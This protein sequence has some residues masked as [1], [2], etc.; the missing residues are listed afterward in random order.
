MNA[1]LL[2]ARIILATVFTVAGIGKLLDLKGS[3][4][5]LIGFG[6]PEWLAGPIG[7]SLPFLELVVSA[8]LLP[9]ATAWWGAAGAFVLLCGF[10]VAISVNVARGKRP[11]CHC[12]GQLHSEPIGPSTLI[13]NSALAFLAA[14]LLFQTHQNPGLGISAVSGR[15]FH[16]SPIAVFLAAAAVA[17]AV[18]QF[19]FVLNL[20]RQNGRLLSRIDALELKVA[21]VPVMPAVQQQTGLKLGTPAP[22]FELPNVSGDQISLAGLLALGKP[23]LLLF[24][25]PQCGPCKALL[26]DLGDSFRQHASKMTPVLISRGESKNNQQYLKQGFEQILLQSDREIAEKYLAWGTPSAVVVDSDGLIRSRLASGAPA[27]KQL[28]NDLV[29]DKLRALPTPARV[30]RIGSRAPAFSLPDLLGNNRA[31]TDFSGDSVLLLFWNPACGFCRRMLPALKHWEDKSPVTDRPQLV[32]VSTGR[33]EENKEMA[34]RST[35]L[36]DADQSAIRM[37]G[38]GGT[39]SGFMIDGESNI[40]SELLLGEDAIFRALSGV[41]PVSQGKRGAPARLAVSTGTD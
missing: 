34:L 8:L 5:A 36:L 27:I 38:S 41:V 9:V 35:V 16:N 12:F 4:T 26:P 29:N 28:V 25:D 11:D 2:L 39:P 23:V 22:A 21:G 15:L 3:R 19:W 7:L 10:V 18:G 20:V 13:R 14:L 24:S 31:L 33:L 1:A 6:F 32:L 30:A 40:A 17:I 37:F